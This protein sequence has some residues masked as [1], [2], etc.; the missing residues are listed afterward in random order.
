MAGEG[1]SNRAWRRRRTGY[2][3]SLR[4][5]F[6]GLRR[7]QTAQR[8]TSRP[9]YGMGMGANTLIHNGRKP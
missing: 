9:G 5:G 7:Q 6:A 8:H 2:W 3:Y 1:M 4:A